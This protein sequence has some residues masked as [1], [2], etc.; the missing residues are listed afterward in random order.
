MAAEGVSTRRRL[1]SRRPMVSQPYSIRDAYPESANNGRGIAETESEADGYDHDACHR[2]I[3]NTAY[4]S[5]PDQ[6]W[7]SDYGKLR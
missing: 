7:T 4:N 3:S 2:A 1:I 5:R 6:Q